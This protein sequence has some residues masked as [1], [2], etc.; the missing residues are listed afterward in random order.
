MTARV[1][2]EPTYAVEDSCDASALVFPFIGQRLL[3]DR[4]AELPRSED[5]LTLGEP[6][7]MFRFGTLAGRKCVLK[8]WP[9]ERVVPIPAGLSSGDY[10]TLWGQWPDGHL[11]ALVRAKQLAVWMLHNQFCG[12]C[13]QPT[14]LSPVEIACV[15][16]V[17]DYR[18]YPCISPVA[19]GLVVRGNEIL[20]ARHVRSQRF[21]PGMYSA[22]AGFVEAGES[23]EECLRREVRE[24]A[25]IEIH[26]LRYFGSQ[27]W[28]YPHSL[29][30]GF[31][32]DYLSGELV[33]QKDEIEDLGWFRLD[34]LPVQPHPGSLARRMIEFVNTEIERT[35]GESGICES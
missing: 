34:D 2:F 33:A 6:L 20:L 35:R 25:G 9:A 8:F 13:G 12:A 4:N 28:P 18:A 16:P 32:A 17:C 24:E 7:R 11:A 1:D 3:I 23:I 10:R 31:I 5:L 21:A 29:M 26:N 19:I 30:I 15:C 22:L 27:S 14:L